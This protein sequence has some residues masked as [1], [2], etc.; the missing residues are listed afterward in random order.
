MQAI[1][2]TVNLNTN[3]TTQLTLYSSLSNN[4]NNNLDTTHT[5]I[6]S[7]GLGARNPHLRT[8]KNDDW[9]K[10]IN[11]PA[12]DANT[13]QIYYTVRGHG[14]SLGWQDTAES[15]YTQFSW[16]KLSYDM[17]A[18]ADYYNLSSF[19]ACGSSMGSATA[20][21]AA[22]NQPERVTA[23]IMIRPPTAWESRK[24]RRHVLLSSA[25]KCH[26]SN[27]SDEK[28]HHVVRA[29]AETD[30]PPLD[31]PLYEKLTIP[32]LILTVK[33]DISHP[34]ST[35]VA[36]KERL[37]TLVQLHIAE[38]SEEADRVWPDVIRTFLIQ[39]KSGTG[40]DTITG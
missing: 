35:A 3:L 20:L 24:D 11:K 10:I 28:Y 30:L 12:E 1:D 22:I 9:I 39:V 6:I 19:I 8:H 18:I 5:L 32:V 7:H 13:N 34:V 29:A 21:Y 17:L 26:D 40:S 38:S 33:G 14:D 36:L 37:S 4:S 31:N 15:D 2:S 16:N 25:K 27:P 23:V